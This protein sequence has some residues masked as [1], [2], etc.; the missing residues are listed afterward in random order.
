MSKSFCIKNNN[1]TILKYIIEQFENLGM[2]QLYISQNS[3]SIYDN[4]IVHYTGFDNSLFEEKLGNILTETILNFYENILIE[5]IINSNYF[6]FFDF[7]KHEIL[8]SSIKNAKSDF[9]INARRYAVYTAWIDYIR[10]N[11]YVILDGFANFRLFKY[12]DF[13]DEIV[14]YSVNNFLVQREYLEFINLLKEYIVS[15]PS[16]IDSAHLIY[17][18]DMYLLYDS[19]LNP[20]PIETNISNTKYLSD[21]SFSKNDYCLNIRHMYC[22]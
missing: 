19:H 15:K 7:E 3:F 22:P 6:Y 4:V 5:N 8:D 9:D 1:K 11:K 13:L 21:I 18:N 16:T 2:P 20:I 14:D 12:K 10:N 17:S